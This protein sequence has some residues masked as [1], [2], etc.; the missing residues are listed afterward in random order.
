MRVR[1][2]ISNNYIPVE[3]PPVPRIFREVQGNGPI[4]DF[5]LID[6]QCGGYQGSG[7]SPA[8]LTADATA[9]GEI[10]LQWTKWPDSHV[11]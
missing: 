10:S 4:M 9:G 6:A 1:T 8:K 7:S 3:D 11:V 5:S 2:S